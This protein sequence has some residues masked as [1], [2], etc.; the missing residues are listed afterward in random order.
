MVGQPKSFAT[1]RF[2]KVTLR[3]TLDACL[4]RLVTYIRPTPAAQGRVAHPDS[5]SNLVTH[6]VS[7]SL[8]GSLSPQF[9]D[10]PSAKQPTVPGRAW[11]AVLCQR[12]LFVVCWF[13][14]CRVSGRAI[15]RCGTHR[16]RYSG[17]QYALPCVFPLFYSASS[18]C[19]PA[20]CTER[21]RREEGRGSC[22][23]KIYLLIV[24]RKIGLPMN[25][26]AHCRS[27]RSESM[28]SWR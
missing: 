3:V 19:V 14:R 10:K 9:G 13:F 12:N 23:S 24:D 1:P 18:Q 15:T 20:D 11:D 27:S 26:R 8:Y 17:F 25:T 7:V 4:W 2:Q 22:K 21:G 5:D 6:I 28:L 16:P